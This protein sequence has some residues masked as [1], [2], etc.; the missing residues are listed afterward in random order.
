MWKQVKV[1]DVCN[2]MTGG[3]P[4]R[5]NPEY[6]DDGDVNWLVSGD[7]NK[8]EIFDCEGRITEKGLDSCSAKYLP[9]NSVLIALNGQGKTRGTVAL[10]RTTAT[11]NQSL[12]AIF[13]K[14]KVELDT[15]YLFY[16]LDG[17]Y[18][19]I[20]R[21]TGDSGND[22]RGLNMPLIRNIS[23]PYPPLAEQQR[24]VAKLDAAFAE[25]DKAAKTIEK[26]SY[27]V[28]ALF[29][30]VLSAEINEQSISTETLAL[31]DVAKFLDYRGKTPTKSP[32]G[33]KLLTAKNVR[34][35]YIRQAPEEFVSEKEYERHMVRG[36]PNTGDV[37]FTTEAPLGLVAQIDND[38]VALGQRLIT[39]QVTNN[40]MRNKFLKYL[41]MSDAYQK[42]I[43][44]KGTGAT[45]K[46]IK[47]KLLKEITLSF[48]A[49][50][51]EQDRRIFRIEVAE[52]KGK[53]VERL[54]E[55]Q[56]ANYQSL[57]SSILAQE[58]KNEAA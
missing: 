20:R 33:T 49:S 39:F 16:V 6:F 34:M 37:V 28:R 7:I 15:K 56:L 18:D 31:K 57:K 21:I 11:C 43:L 40:I 36:F 9:I 38:D 1:G 42:E 41:L 50:L 27:H 45:V 46:G 26:K 2:L 54:Y 10:L 13:P 4:S 47:A 32:S 14:E 30:K 8:R 25:I 19:K 52:E 17:M 12:V 24:I 44:Q 48:P 29:S 55:N 53:E 23:I 35:G 22:R 51:K 3:T 5:N 58:L